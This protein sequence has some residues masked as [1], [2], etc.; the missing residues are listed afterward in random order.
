MTKS[1]FQNERL[2]TQ[3][4]PEVRKSGGIVPFSPE[5]KSNTSGLLRGPAGN[6]H[7]EKHG[8][9]GRLITEEER[10]DRDLWEQAVID[11]LGG[12]PA[13]ST[14]QHALIHAAGFLRIKL[15]RID[16]A[17][18]EGMEPAPEHT[19]AAFNS[20]RLLLAQIGLERKAKQGPSLREYLQQK[21]GS[22]E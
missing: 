18:N 21:T 3:G 2:K 12:S 7:A 1:K 4:A 16:K 8:F 20:F 14:A 10:R 5:R 19:M 13:V 22:E 11:D 17:F 15:E 9:Y 6:R